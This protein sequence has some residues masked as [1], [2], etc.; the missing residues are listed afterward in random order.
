M[1]Y[2]FCY[3]CIAVSLVLETTESIVHTAHICNGR[4]FIT[5]RWSFDMLDV[6][7]L[8]MVMSATIPSL[9]K[10]TDNYIIVHNTT[11]KETQLKKSTNN[12]K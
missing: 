2:D 9:L 7:W 5:Y 4:V 6:Y 3:C 8:C 1:W 11:R 10:I 12:P